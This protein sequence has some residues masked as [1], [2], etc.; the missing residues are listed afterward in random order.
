MHTRADRT[1]SL[2]LRRFQT[3]EA[4]TVLHIPVMDAL[5][6]KVQESEVTGGP[7]GACLALPE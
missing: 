4:S 2:P 1:H 3:L 7:K 5:A 6:L